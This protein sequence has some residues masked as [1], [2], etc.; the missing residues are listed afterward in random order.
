MLITVCVC[1]CPL[2]LLLIFFMYAREEAVSHRHI[3]VNAEGRE[4]NPR[5]QL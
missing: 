5:Q 3:P 1:V 2:L 4:M